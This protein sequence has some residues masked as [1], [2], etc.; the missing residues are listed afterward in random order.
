MC[1]E[2]LGGARENGFAGVKWLM[3]S[4]ERGGERGFRGFSGEGERM[5]AFLRF[6]PSPRKTEKSC[7][8]F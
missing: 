6:P 1:A 7:W 5:G 4:K 2:I 8:D 3:F